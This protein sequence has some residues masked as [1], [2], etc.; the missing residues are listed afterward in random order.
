ML[1]E[2]I[3]LG[4]KVLSVNLMPNNIFDFPLNGICSLNR[5][6]YTEFEQR[7]D[8]IYRLSKEEYLTKIDGNPKELMEFNKSSS[9]IDKIK[10]TLDNFI[11]D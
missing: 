10:N 4:N 7:V 11:S 9:A 5:C 3:A 1:R 6:T 2:N 8:E